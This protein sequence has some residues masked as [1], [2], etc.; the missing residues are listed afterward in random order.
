MIS[1][2]FG[3][4]LDMLKKFETRPV[5]GALNYISQTE[6]KLRSDLEVL[7]A[8]KGSTLNLEFG[9]QRKSLITCLQDFKVAA[10]EYELGGVTPAADDALHALRDG[11]NFEALNMDQV[12]H[13]HT[14][15]LAAH[16]T[17][18]HILDDTSIYVLSR[19]SADLV[20]G[21]R[22]GF[23]EHVEAAFPSST[24]DAREASKC[25]G[26]E[27]WTACVMH[28]MRALEPALK[29]LEDAVSVKIPKEQWGDKINQIEAAIKVMSKATHDKADVQ[30]FSD[31][32]TQFH[33]IKTAWRNYAHHLLHTY[34]EERATEIYDAARRF[35][36]HLSVRLSEPI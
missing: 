27:R 33:F 10:R 5:L 16:S 11:W 6:R 8:N 7:R 21:D 35:T 13:V 28:C 36:R 23:G 3:S 12:T 29:A 32:A 18:L 17:V 1:A 14:V 25:L 34:D 26:L 24:Y 4:L 31:S 15:L 20:N 2:R 30:W 9:E 22:V 19:G